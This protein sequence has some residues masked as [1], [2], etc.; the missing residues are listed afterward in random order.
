MNN[1][2][3]TESLQTFAHIYNRGLF[4]EKNDNNA[5]AK[6]QNFLEQ[7]IEFLMRAAYHWS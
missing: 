7:Q 5:L 6:I 4:S 3:R 1:S 2:K